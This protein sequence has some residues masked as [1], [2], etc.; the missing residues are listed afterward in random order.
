MKNLSRLRFGRLDKRFE[1]RA[2][3]RK[4]RAVEELAGQ[5]FSPMVFEAITSGP[6][7]ESLVDAGLEETMVTAYQ[8]IRAVQD[9]HPGIDLRTA[10]FIVA[11]N[12]IAADY[13]RRGI[14]P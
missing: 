2:N 1:Q 8:E 12:K 5:K 6:S 13:N 11:I 9:Q 3:E 7:E 14:F 10:A 4:L